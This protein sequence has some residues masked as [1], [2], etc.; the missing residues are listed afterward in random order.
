M[1]PIRHELGPLGAFIFPL[2]HRGFDIQYTAS[3][4]A[5]FYATLHP[6]ELRCILKQLCCTLY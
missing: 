6:T 4:I 1:L 5:S 2:D 3:P